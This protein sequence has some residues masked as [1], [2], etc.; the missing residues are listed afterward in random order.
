MIPELDQH[1]LLP[2]GIHDCTLD[3]ISAAFCWNPHRQALFERLM[4]F[5]VSEWRPLGLPCPLFVDGSFTRNKPLPEDIDVV[6]DL[7]V[8]ND[9]SDVLRGL[10]VWF[11][12]SEIKSTY[13]LDVWPRHPRIP[14][15]L[16][17]FFQYLGEKAS[18]EL[19]LPIKHPK[20][21]LRIRP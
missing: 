15:D 20:G 18:A 16:A 21:I 9:D 4:R 8:L 17:A 19:R 12:H 2:A 13:N 7:S 6:M 10:S 11:R 14:N 5:L 1:G 3:E